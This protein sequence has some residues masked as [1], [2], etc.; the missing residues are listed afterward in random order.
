[1]VNLTFASSSYG[2][3][4]GSKNITITCLGEHMSRVDV[5]WLRYKIDNPR[6][7][8]P[9]FSDR[10]Y[11]GKA[12]AKYHVNIFELKNDTIR[13][14]MTIFDIEK[15]DFLHA[16][17][18][19]CNIYKR[20]SNTNRARANTTLVEIPR[21]EVTN[22]SFTYDNL[23]GKALKDK[24]VQLSLITKKKILFK[25]FGLFSYCYEGAINTSQYF[26]I[27][28]SALVISGATFLLYFSSES[29]KIL[30]QLFKFN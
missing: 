5:V 12:S 10:K 11:I 22:I 6:L 26:L 19:E 8:R 9:I 18:C 28:I 25:E 16:Y 13:T 23:T 20:C 17:K 4:I 7:V 1:M 14:S 24:I 3:Q 2:A 27:V 29:K 30:F 21:V 15:D